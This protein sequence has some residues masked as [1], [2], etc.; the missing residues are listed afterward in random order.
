MLVRVTCSACANPLAQGACIDCALCHCPFCG[1]EASTG[2]PHLLATA[3]VVED[4]E[5]RPWSGEATATLLIRSPFANR[6]RLRL[7]KSTI[8]RPDWTDAQK[9]RALG[10]FSRV[11]P[12]WEQH[13]GLWREPSDLLLMEG[14]VEIARIDVRRVQVDVDSAPDPDFAD[15]FFCFDAS[16]A[17]ATLHALVPTLKERLRCLA[18]ATPRGKTPPRGLRCRSC[19]LPLGETTSCPACDTGHCPY[20]GVGARCWTHDGEPGAA[21]DLEECSHLVAATEDWGDEWRV[22]PFNWSDVPSLPDGGSDVEWLN[23]ELAAAFGESAYL[24]EAYEGDLAAQPDTRSLFAAWAT[25]AP[26][27]LVSIN[28]TDSSMGETGGEDYYSPDTATFRTA[29]QRLER[30]LE[31]GFRRL[32]KH[33]LVRSAGRTGRRA[34]IRDQQSA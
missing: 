9:R 27:P 25:H 6:P 23:C 15:C 20:C 4:G 7:P 8:G 2:C 34:L 18:A 26:V 5:E 3:R 16:S 29:I 33:D 19:D 21:L 13:R 28:W 31:R 24:L 1:A 17:I 30:D 10:R 22:S 32:A 11:L 12:A 14:L